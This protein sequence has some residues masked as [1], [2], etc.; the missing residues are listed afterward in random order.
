MRWDSSTGSVT[1]AWSAAQPAV[2]LGCLGTIVIVAA[3]AWLFPPLRKV[4][5]LAKEVVR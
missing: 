2:V 3:W 1:A 4:D 5:E